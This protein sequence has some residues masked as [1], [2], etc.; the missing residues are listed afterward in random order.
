MKKEKRW[1]R[2]RENR[3]RKMWIRV[4]K[5]EYEGEREEKEEG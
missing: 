2:R 3:E 5:K 1:S 4:K